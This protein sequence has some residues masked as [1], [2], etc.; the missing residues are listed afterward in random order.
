MDNYGWFVLFFVFSFDSPL[1]RTIGTIQWL[2]VSVLVKFL[3]AAASSTPF[4]LIFFP[5]M[6]RSFKNVLTFSTSIE[7]N[8]QRNKTVPCLGV[9]FDIAGDDGWVH[10]ITHGRISVSVA[11]KY[12]LEKIE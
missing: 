4:K 2:A 12:L 5:R 3:R 9:N 6:D 11:R 8:P 1:E 10:D 7:F